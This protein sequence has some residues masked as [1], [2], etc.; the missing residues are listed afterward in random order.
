MEAVMQIIAYGVIIGALYGLVAIGLALLLGVMGYLNIAHG[1]FIM[2]GGYVSFWLFSL[3]HIDPFVSIP[4]VMLVM[5]IMGLILYRVLF[6]PLLKFPV[7]WRIGNS[8]LV[9]FGLLWVLDNAATWLWTSDVR[10]I[11]TSYTGEVFNLFG[12][13]LAYTGLGGLSLA[14]MIIFAL[15]L[16]LTKTYFGKS[17][18]A[19]AQDWEWFAETWTYILYA[20]GY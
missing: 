3:W 7:G 19:T 10:S 13:R 12:V 14:I 20:Q 8:M 1:T 16:L 5:F 6:S 9:S 18:R 11:T 17:V 15:H 2:L 4:L